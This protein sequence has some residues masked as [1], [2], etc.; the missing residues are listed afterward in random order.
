MISLEID[1]SIDVFLGMTRY[2]PVYTIAAIH[3]K[4]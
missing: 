1:S 2:Q 3:D 4:P